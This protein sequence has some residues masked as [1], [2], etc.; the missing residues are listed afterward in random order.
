MNKSE[1]VERLFLSFERAFQK[2]FL[3]YLVVV[4]RYNKRL[5]EEII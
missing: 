1:R 3:L 5:N 4:L 2:G